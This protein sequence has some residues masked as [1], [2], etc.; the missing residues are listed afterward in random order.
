VQKHLEQYAKQHTAEAN[1]VAP[2]VKMLVEL[3]ICSCWLSH[4]CLPVDSI[5]YC[6]A[7]L[8]SKWCHK[9]HA[10]CNQRT[11]PAAI[12]AAAAASIRWFLL[13]PRTVCA[14]HGNA[15]H[16]VVTHV[17]RN[18]QHQ[19]DVVVL[20]LLRSTAAAA[21]ARSLTKSMQDIKAMLNVPNVCWLCPHGREH[22]RCCIGWEASCA[23]WQV[24]LV[25]ATHPRSCCFIRRVLMLL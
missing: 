25:E 19:A 15:A 9:P 20:H 18:L 1:D 14:I 3:S 24:L 23:A 5:D 11:T 8:L 22:R 4:A 21:A 6:A 13:L 16:V 7:C 10:P 17:L 12:A 2:G